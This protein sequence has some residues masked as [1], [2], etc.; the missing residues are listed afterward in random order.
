MISLSPSII[1]IIGTHCWGLVIKDNLLCEEQLVE[2]T[3]QYEYCSWL[4]LPYV[5]SWTTEDSGLKVCEDNLLG[6]VFM[7]LDNTQLSHFRYGL[8]L[9]I[10][11]S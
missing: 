3:E 7:F 2:T 6:H 11:P 10:E 5:K 8:A 1:N 4:F 9:L